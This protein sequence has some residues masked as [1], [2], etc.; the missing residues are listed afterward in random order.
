M[1]GAA[2]VFDADIGIYELYGYATAQKNVDRLIA[3]Q[4]EY[5]ESLYE[6]VVPTHIGFD[7]DLGRMFTKGINTMDMA[8]EIIDEKETYQRIIQK[9]KRKAEMFRQGMAA[10]DPEEREV[11]LIRYL[12]KRDETVLTSREF[13]DLL[14]IAEIKLVK[15][16]TTERQRQLNKQRTEYRQSLMDQVAAWK[17]GVKHG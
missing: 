6:K 11:I 10:L 12:G 15:W 7:R 16:L 9:H 4:E 3:N 2:Y 17:E 14:Y 5:Y 13:Y 8:L 1:G